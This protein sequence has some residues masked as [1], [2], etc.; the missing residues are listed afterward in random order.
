MG[1][2]KI[3]K[4]AHFYDKISV[5]V[6]ELNAPLKVGEK[7][8]FK[9]GEEEFTQTI[10]SMQIER[11]QIKAA[12]KGQAIGLRTAQPVHEGAEVFKVTE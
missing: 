1:E 7:I 4:V 10:D 8:K 3:G 11:E 6:I 12:K 5:A 2:T 9:R